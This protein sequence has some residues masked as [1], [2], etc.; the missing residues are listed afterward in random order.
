MKRLAMIAIFF[1]LPALFA[2]AQNGVITGRILGIDG[3][4][5]SGVR[6]AVAAPN[7]DGQI[8]ADT[9]LGIARTDASGNYRIENVPP[10]RY[11]II[12]G[13][14]D[15]P[16]Y[17]PGVPNG[18][19]ATIIAIAPGSMIAGLDFALTTSPIPPPQQFVVSK[20]VLQALTEQVSRRVQQNFLIMLN[21]RVVVEGATTPPDLSSL[22]VILRNGIAAPTQGASR[23]GKATVGNNGSIGLELELGEY[24]V[25]LERRDGKPLSAYVVK[26]ITLGSIDLLKD[27]LRVNGP[28]SGELVITLGWAP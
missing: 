1:T 11:G 13:V 26:S 12:A 7:A 19:G 8:T 17:Y 15:S 9:L 25:S 21:G 27:K 14:V 24:T 10:G 22:S 28:L 6:V 18:S 3:Q 20:H 23:D 4:P 5:A 2:K 16:T